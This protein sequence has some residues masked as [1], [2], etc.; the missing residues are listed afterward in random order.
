MG[1]G[2]YAKLKSISRKS[3]QKELSR[4]YE[5]IKLLLTAV[6]TEKTDEQLT[7]FRNPV[8]SIF[9]VYREQEDLKSPRSAELDLE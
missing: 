4:L 8:F 5:Q 7:Y 3:D 1:R 9:N 6:R 2:Q